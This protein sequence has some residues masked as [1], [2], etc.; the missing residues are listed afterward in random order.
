MML[1]V[2][3]LGTSIATGN[4]SSNYRPRRGL[5]LIVLLTVAVVGG[6]GRG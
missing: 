5:W 4:I 2:T 1:L 6:R 3:L